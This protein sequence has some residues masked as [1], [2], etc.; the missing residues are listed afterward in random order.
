MRLEVLLP[1][2]VFADV[3]DVLRMIADTAAGSL[4]LLPHRLDCALALRPGILT[5][6]T[7]AAGRV[8]IAVDDGV[9]VKTGTAV[10]VAVRRPSAAPI[11]KRCR[12][13]WPRI[14]RTRRR[15]APG[16]GAMPGS[17]ARSCGALRARP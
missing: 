8:Y 12:M 2:K 15:P 17:K 3:T 11:L 10:L 9:L 7:A 6:E 13:R 16:A 4:G 14:S 5:Y 1:F